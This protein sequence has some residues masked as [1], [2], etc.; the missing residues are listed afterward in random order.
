MVFYFSGSHLSVVIWVIKVSGHVIWVATIISS[1]NT[2]WD[3]PGTLKIVAGILLSKRL[4]ISSLS[5]ANNFNHV[6]YTVLSICAELSLSLLV[7]TFDSMSSCT[8]DSGSP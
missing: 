8:A 4:V 3:R 1:H 7:S 5:S 6:V 2:N